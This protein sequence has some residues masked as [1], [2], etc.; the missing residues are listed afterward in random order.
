MEQQQTQKNLQIETPEFWEEA[1]K[2]AREKL[3]SGR[4][5]R[6]LQESVKYW[7]QRAGNFGKNVL[8]EGGKK[9]VKRVFDWLENQGVDFENMKVL[10]IGAGPGAFALA[11]AQKAK[12]VVALEPAEAMNA[13]LKKRAAQNGLKNIR[14]IQETWEEVDLEKHNLKQEFELV[15]A[16]MSPGINNGE[17]LDK[18][19]SCA[20]Q[21]CFISGFAGKRKNDV[22]SALWQLMFG[23]DVPDQTGNIIYLLNL[24]YAKG[25]DLNFE[26]W[27]ERITLESTLDEA[28]RGIQADLQKYGVEEHLRNDPRIHQFVEDKLAEGIFRQETISRQGQILVR[29]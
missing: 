3:L 9:R 4:N 15:F 20:K 22:L 25:Y 29:L 7:N 21:Y 10:D 6:T 19:L 5:R 12:E 28:V 17:T 11:F 13:F 16:S 23:E 14:I 27:E 24:L 18:A 1:W 2:Q 26:V 8:G